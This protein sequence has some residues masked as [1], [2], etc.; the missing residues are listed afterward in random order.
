[1]KKDVHFWIA[2]VAR[3]IL[4]LIT[5][6]AIMVIP[7]MARTFL[8]LPIAIVVS[9][10]CLAAYGVLDSAIVFITSFVVSSRAPKAALRLQ[11]A[12]GVIV[13][14]L[15]LSVIYDRVNLQ[16]FLYLIA[17]QALCTTVAEFV[18]ARHAFTRSTSVWNYAA[19]A[20]ALLFLIAYSFAAIVLVDALSA[21]HI[22]WLIYGYLLA[23]GFAQCLTAARMLYTDL[24]L[25]VVGAG[26]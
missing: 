8:L 21:Q 3:G 5:G 7:D 25:M 1:M 15:L 23:L 14:V 17:F 11:G 16:W 19:A 26:G 4:A 22:A 13:G 20:V 18:F 6:S 24:Q 10:F 2:T 9:I 12:F